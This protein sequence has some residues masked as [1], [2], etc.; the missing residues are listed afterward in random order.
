M[1]I[2]TKNQLPSPTEA[3]TLLY[4]KQRLKKDN[5][6]DWCKLQINNALQEVSELWLT[7]NTLKVGLMPTP[8]DWKETIEAATVLC[9]NLRDNGY[10]AYYEY[11]P[12]GPSA[13][14]F[15]IIISIN[16]EELLNPP[17]IYIDENNRDGWQQEYEG[18]IIETS[19]KTQTY[20][21]YRWK[22]LD[23]ARKGVIHWRSTDKVHVQFEEDGIHY[24]IRTRPIINSP[25][26]WFNWL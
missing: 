7:E 1:E 15:N 19:D 5:Y 14:F 13:S 23:E 22:G 18:E 21:Y 25:K 16:D 26:K 4:N 8:L 3:E 10:L 24:K 12:G 6:I 17:K 11:S 2:L 9:D 20:K